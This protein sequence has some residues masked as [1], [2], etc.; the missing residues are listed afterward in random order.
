[1]YLY[2]YYPLNEVEQLKDFENE[3]IES[4]LTEYGRKKEPF[5]SLLV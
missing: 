3:N 5:R 1:M 4:L 2:H